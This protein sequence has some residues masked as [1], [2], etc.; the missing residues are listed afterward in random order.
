MLRPRFL[1]FIVNPYAGV[2]RGSLA[3]LR[4]REAVRRIGPDAEIRVLHRGE[5]ITAAVE[6]GIYQ[7]ATD[8][9]AV[10]GDGTVGGVAGALAGTGT[11]MGIVPAGTANML[12]QELNIPLSA[13]SA[14]RLILGPHATRCIDAMELD[15]RRF[16]YQIVLGPGAEALIHLTP[17]LKVLFGRSVYALLG[18]RMFMDFRPLRVK[19]LIDDEEIDS[20]VSHIIIA[21]AGIL[22]FRPFRLGSG[23]HVDDGHIEVILM[24]G[25]SRASVL[26]A[27]LDLLSGNYGTGSS[28]RYLIARKNVYIETEPPTIIKADGEF[29]GHTPLDMTVLPGAVRVIVPPR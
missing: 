22:G 25:Q 12:A 8:V 18:L 14:L 3:Q 7:G 21:N 11:T 5:D 15:D 16:V 19:G 29:F 10:G 24:E 4:V 6:Q 9:I 26:A 23:I 27:G 28:L 13:P 2:G 20:R 17:E 1:F